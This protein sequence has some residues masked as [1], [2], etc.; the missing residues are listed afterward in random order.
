MYKQAYYR[1]VMDIFIRIDLTE[2]MIENVM[3]IKCIISFDN[4]MVWSYKGWHL[5]W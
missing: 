3:G 5:A 2:G 1:P 4:T